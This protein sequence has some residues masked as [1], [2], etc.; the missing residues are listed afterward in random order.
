L[1]NF[2]N[3]ATIGLLPIQ[4]SNPIVFFAED[5]QMVLM[6]VKL[7]NLLLFNDFE[8][9]T[10]YPKKIVDSGIGEE[11]LDGFPNFRYK[12]LV[13]LM[14]P[15]ASGKTA[16]GHILLSIF[17][18]INSKEYNKIVEL[19]EDNNR[20]AFFSLDIA[21]SSGELWRIETRIEPISEEAYKSDDI[22]VFVNK[23]R[24][25][26][27]DNYEK[28]AERLTLKAVQQRT[29]YATALETVPKLTWGFE[30]PFENS[31]PRSFID[32]SGTFIGVL[33]QTLITL[34][35]RIEDVY[36][37][38]KNH[39]IIEIKYPHGTVLLKEGR[40]VDNDIL[41]QGTLE[42]IGIAYLIA[43]IRTHSADFY[44]CDEKFSHIYSDAE[45]AFLSLLID[46]LGSNEQLFI[47]SHN[48]DI[49]D[50]KIP[51]H[52]FAFLRRDTMDDNR[53]SC[54]FASEY[55]K[56][57]TES[58]KNAVENDVFSTAPDLSGIFSLKD[59]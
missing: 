12:K 13:I 16:F 25:L 18:F 30:F 49:L 35:P 10:S 54:V 32:Y 7:D 21:Y 36:Y 48:L 24:I 3:N 33:K 41:S 42:G 14:G 38:S 52:S 47:T 20:E 44:Y 43:G 8:L 11:H 39:E 45:R 19:I 34:D 15:N 56:K 55:L 1:K 31:G 40:V 53:I 5:I 4:G 17:H 51:K 59:I 37:P 50:M 28:C 2:I 27:N 46:L 29:F 58:V 22:E 57:N 9:C 26:S 23:T 6:N